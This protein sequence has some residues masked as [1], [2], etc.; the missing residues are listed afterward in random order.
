M[1]VT[2]P[3]YQVICCITVLLSD[4][5]I[6]LSMIKT[7]SYFMAHMFGRRLVYPGSLA[8]TQS[9]M[10]KTIILVS[11]IHVCEF[12]KQFDLLTFWVM[13]RYCI[14]GPNNNLNIE[15]YTTQEFLF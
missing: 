12:M 3:Y 7:P 13:S 9:I 14:D 2:L 11:Y 15:L 6:T 4:Y 1:E 5:V 8:V 10:G